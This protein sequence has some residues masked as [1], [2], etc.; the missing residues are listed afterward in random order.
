M[1]NV[2]LIKSAFLGFYQIATSIFANRKTPKQSPHQ[3]GFCNIATKK[4][5]LPL[6]SKKTPLNIDN[7]ATQITNKNLEQ[8]AL[9]LP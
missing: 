5:F 1:L 3:F 9:P 2:P 8:D 4:V 7:N 6:Y